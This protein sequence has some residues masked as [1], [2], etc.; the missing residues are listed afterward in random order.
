MMLMKLDAFA[1]I[2]AVVWM[3]RLEGKASQ[4][5]SSDRWS[6]QSSHRSRR[7][8]GRARDHFTRTN[9]FPNYRHKSRSAVT[10]ESV[11]SKGQ[12]R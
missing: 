5:T 9:M 10:A 12:R 2:V 4:P 3:P 6:H 8:S 11:A 7:W 1:A